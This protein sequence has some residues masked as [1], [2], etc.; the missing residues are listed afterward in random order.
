MRRDD[1]G[2][3]SARFRRRLHA[4]W[5]ILTRLCQVAASS[6][7]IRARVQTLVVSV[8]LLLRRYARLRPRRS[9]PVTVADHRFLVRD[10]TEVLGLWEVFV[11]ECYEH[12]ELPRTASVVI[13]LGCSVGG[14]LVWFTRRF[15]TARVIGVEAD[16]ITAG[17]A[18]MNTEGY[19]SVLVENAA[20]TAVDGASVRFRRVP[21]RSW[22]SSLTAES[23]ET[24]E[25]RSTS[26][27]GLIAR[28]ML[29]GV[30]ILKVDIEGAEH[31]ALANAA[32][33]RGVGFVVGEY[34]PS[35]THGWSDFTRPLAKQFRFDPPPDHDS[36]APIDFV[37]VR[38]H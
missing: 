22:G 18:R 21:N 2:G 12:D 10:H 23:G 14:A 29:Q 34:H 20:V 25:V 27:Q 16:P 17:L 3:A 35:R 9:H 19:G 8:A 24:V 7:G 11:A 28:H 1:R 15:P 6:H 26:V 31:S 13:D 5:W 32:A 33:L 37:A 4:Q 38:R 36:D 30:D